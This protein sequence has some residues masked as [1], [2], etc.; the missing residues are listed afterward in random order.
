VTL[1]DVEK[2]IAASGFDSTCTR[3]ALRFTMKPG[4]EVS[5]M[6]FYFAERGET[7][8]EGLEMPDAETALSEAA[9]TALLMARERAGCFNAGCFNTDVS[10]D[11]HSDQGRVGRVT[12][13]VTVERS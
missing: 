2:V 13:I 8:D 5:D 7:A 3:R 9:D 12:V 1:V 6:R 10:L 11:V 4:G